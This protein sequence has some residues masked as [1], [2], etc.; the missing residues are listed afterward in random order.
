MRALDQTFRKQNN[1]LYQFDIQVDF[2]VNDQVDFKVR[3]NIN[4]PVAF[5]LVTFADF[6]DFCCLLFSHHMLDTKGL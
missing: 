3:V 1:L 5:K 4:L 2:K 6:V